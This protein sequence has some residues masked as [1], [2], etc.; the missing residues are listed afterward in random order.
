LTDDQSQVRIG[1]EGEAV[2]QILRLARLKAIEWPSSEA[3]RTEVASNPDAE[4]RFIKLA[5]RG[6]F[7]FLTR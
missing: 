3:L 6:A 4:D 2:K 5:V 7:E 1:E